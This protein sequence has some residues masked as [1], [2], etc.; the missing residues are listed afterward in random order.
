MDEFAKNY[1]YP[2][3]L[4]RK[5]KEE[6]KAEQERAEQ[7]E[8]EAAKIIKRTEAKREFLKCKQVGEKLHLKMSGGMS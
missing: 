3:E 8:I 7:I 6:S 1:N 5:I 4:V 2:P